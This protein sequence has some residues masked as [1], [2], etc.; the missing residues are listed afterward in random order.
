VDDSWV[1]QRSKGPTFSF[2][3]STQLARIEGRIQQ[4]EHDDSA[5]VGI[6]RQIEVAHSTLRDKAF[7]FVAAYP[8]R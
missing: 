7:D 5:R 3:S 2:E 1:V 8:G 4:L 6:P